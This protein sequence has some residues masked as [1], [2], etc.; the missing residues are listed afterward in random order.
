MAPVFVGP[1]QQKLSSRRKI[2]VFVK[3]VHR[4]IADAV[5]KEEQA[6]D[7][8]ADDKNPGAACGGRHVFSL[9]RRQKMSKM[10]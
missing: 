8:Y 7:K 10:N 6:D 1:F 9:S 3:N 5:Q 4:D 2:I